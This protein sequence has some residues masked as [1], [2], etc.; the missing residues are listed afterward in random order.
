MTF[1]SLFIHF[2]PSDMDQILASSAMQATSRLNSFFLYRVSMGWGYSHSPFPG[3]SPASLLSPYHRRKAWRKLLRMLFGGEF[4]SGEWQRENGLSVCLELVVESWESPKPIFRE[5]R[6]RSGRRYLWTLGASNH[7]VEFLKGDSNQKFS[8]SSQSP[9]P[10]YQKKKGHSASYCKSMCA[11][12]VGLKRWISTE[13]E[14][15]WSRCLCHLHNCCNVG[16][17]FTGTSFP[18]PPNKIKRDTYR[19]IQLFQQKCS[20]H[21][22]CNLLLCNAFQL[23]AP[24][25]QEEEKED[26]LAYNLH[27]TKQEDINPQLSTLWDLF[28]WGWRQ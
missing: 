26:M 28:P 16:W 21:L 1:T 12:G 15:K 13:M 27:T 25:N 24:G 11:R 17:Y 10:K 20:A 18:P 19:M 6:E 5:E 22:S 14:E 3:H 8:V 23:W 9:E 7:S 2:M 4:P